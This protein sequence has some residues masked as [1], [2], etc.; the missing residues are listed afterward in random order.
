LR[1]V[2]T[3]AD[4]FDVV[5]K[6]SVATGV[7]QSP[8]IVSVTNGAIILALGANDIFDATIGTVTNF[9][10][11]MGGATNDTDD[12]AIGGAAS[13][14]TTAGSIAPTAWSTWTSG[15][16]ITA[17]LALKPAV[18]PTVTSSVVSEITTITATGGGNVT[19]DGGSPILQR[20]VAWST[21]ANPTTANNFANTAGTTGFF[22]SSITGLTA[23]TS[24]FAAAFAFN[25]I[26]SSYGSDQAFSTDA[27][28]PSSPD[29]YQ[30]Y[31]GE[32]SSI[33]K[34]YRNLI[35]K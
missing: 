20:G 22:Q 24:Y 18:A 14:L 4:P 35:F 9:A 8:S 26:G 12:I 27:P 34:Q 3:A 11:N 21:S 32:F 33:P 1:G 19:A 5:F 16:Y 7:P 31:M 17:T 2:T 30:S 6:S 29:P 23:G 10:A 25:A 28:P 15:A 13:V